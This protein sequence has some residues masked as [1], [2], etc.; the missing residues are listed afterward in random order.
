MKSGYVV[1]IILLILAVFFIVYPWYL[2]S[3][4]YSSIDATGRTT[5][6]MIGLL[7]LV[8]GIIVIVA[9]RWKIVR[10]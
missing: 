6:V 4:P 7:L 9:S 1:G 8:V 5:M 2:T 10:K 3:V